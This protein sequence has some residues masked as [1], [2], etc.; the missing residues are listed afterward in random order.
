[1]SLVIGIIDKEKVVFASDS[2]VSIGGVRK[3]SYLR[4]NHKIWHP[5]EKTDVIM[6]T[7]GNVR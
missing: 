7:V 3:V 2:Q 1:M 4:S 6:G 5:D